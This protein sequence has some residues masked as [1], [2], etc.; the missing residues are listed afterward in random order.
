MRNDS[1]LFL[2]SVTNFHHFAEKNFLLQ[3]P[4]RRQPPSYPG[5]FNADHDFGHA[6][7]HEDGAKA[8]IA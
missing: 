7:L 2:L 3:N 8:L 5:K 1:V 4:R 6:P